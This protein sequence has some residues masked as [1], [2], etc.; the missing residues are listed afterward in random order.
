MSHTMCEFKRDRAEDSS[1]VERME[2]ID[3]HIDS[4]THA[5]THTHTHRHTNSEGQSREFVTFHV[6]I[7]RRSLL[8][9]HDRF[10]ES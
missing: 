10:L 3:T 1:D 7:D 2:E 8:L 9:Y 4:H 6:G 5:H